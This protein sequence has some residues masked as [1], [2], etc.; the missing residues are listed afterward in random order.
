[1]AGLCRRG[2]VS[3]LS[4][5]GSFRSNV[6]FKVG[7]VCTMISRVSVF[8]AWFHSCNWKPLGTWHPCVIAS[9]V[10]RPIYRTIGIQLEIIMI[11]QSHCGAN[12][13]WTVGIMLTSL[14]RVK[15]MHAKKHPWSL[16][17]NNIHCSKSV[18]IFRPTMGCLTLTRRSWSVRFLL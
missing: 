10:D 8:D 13:K 6:D 16:R 12:E 5:L 2:V 15:C 11:V 17:K 7:S 18:T 9:M 1:M 14:A 4:S 3:T